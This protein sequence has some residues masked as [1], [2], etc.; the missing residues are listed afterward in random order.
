[1]HKR[2]ISDPILSDLQKKIV[3]LSGPRQCGKTT[4]ARSLSKKFAYL[5]YDSVKDRKLVIDQAWDRKVDLVVL[6]ELHKMKSWKRWLK[7]IYDTEGVSPSIL[8]TGS[9]RLDIAKKMGDSLAGRYFYFRLHPLTLRE[10]RGH[11]TLEKNFKRLSEQGGFPEPFFSKEKDFYSRWA[12]THTDIILRQDLIDLENIT[13]I[14]QIEL[15]VE[16]LRHKVG[17][18]VSYQSLAEDLQVE[19]ATVKRWLTAL[20][21]MFVI[22]RVTP[23]SKNIARAILKTSKYY[24]YDTGQVPDDKG[25][26]YEN[27]IANELISAIHFEQDTRGR[28]MSLHYLRNKDNFEV[29]FA[30]VE[31]EK[32][33]L[34]LEAKYSDDSPSKAFLRLKPKNYMPKAVQLV[35]E[36]DREKQYPFGVEIRNASK[37]LQDIDL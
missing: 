23:W 13:K 9:A 25:M 18:P 11:S 5:N 12:R 36:L 17:S 27:L 19:I 21:N 28:K 16:L 24:F 20:E 30:I 31:K 35:A 15:M 4:L 2:L 3:L 22:F 14:S 33:S 1:M 34:M 37:W 29:D 32:I 10:L 7:G 6:D 26:R 8:V